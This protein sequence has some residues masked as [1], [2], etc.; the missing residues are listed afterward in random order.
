MKTASKTL[1]TLFTSTFTLSAFTI[2]G[3]Y[4]I[5]PLMKKRFVDELHWI[6]EEEMLEMIAIGQSA[7][8]P[9]AINTAILLGHKIAGVTG[10]LLAVLGTSLPPLILLSILSVGYDMVKDIKLI[11]AML[12][13]MQAGVAAVIC[14][15]VITMGAGVVKKKQALSLAIMIAA[16]LAAAVFGVNVVFVILAAGLVGGIASALRGRKKK[17]AK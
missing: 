17:E 3:G 6:E 5:V 7:P 15:V 8:G 13:G 11:A 9:I 12:R 1:R 14:D 4:V 10:A 16:F 2:G